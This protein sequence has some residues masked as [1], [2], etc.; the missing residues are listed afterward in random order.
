MYLNTAHSWPGIASKIRQLTSGP[1]RRRP[2]VFTKAAKLV[3]AFSDEQI[4][5]EIENG[6]L[7]EVNCDG[8][9]L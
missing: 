4:G 6:R 9:D 1:A 7:T 2:A 8:Q 3:L 5:A